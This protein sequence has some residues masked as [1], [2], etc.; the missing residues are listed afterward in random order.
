MKYQDLLTSLP[1]FGFDSAGL[2]VEA[3]RTDGTFNYLANLNH[4]GQT[5]A[6]ALRMPAIGADPASF[7]SDKMSMIETTEFLHHLL[8]RGVKLDDS[9]TLHFTG[10]SVLVSSD[11]VQRFL[12]H[13][14]ALP[15]LQMTDRILNR[16][17]TL[18]GQAVNDLPDDIAH[19]I[20]SYQG[21]FLFSVGAPAWETLEEFPHLVDKV[22]CALATLHA[23]SGRGHRISDPVALDVL[24]T[25]ES[26]LH[27]DASSW[28]PA[29]N[30][31]EGRGLAKSLRRWNVND[32]HKRRTLV[33]R[34]R[35]LRSDAGRTVCRQAFNT[36]LP[37][38][39]STASSLHCFSHGDAHGGNFVTVQY[40]Y[41]LDQTDVV[42]DRVF[43]NDIFQQR[44]DIHKVAVT[45]LDD[46]IA[47]D[48]V[49]AV[50]DPTCIAV[51][52]PHFEVHPIDLDTATVSSPGRDTLHLYDAIVFSLS[53]S[54]ILRLHGNEAL[55]TD[56]LSCYLA[57]LDHRLGHRR[58]SIHIAL[59]NDQP[60]QSDHGGGCLVQHLLKHRKSY[61]LKGF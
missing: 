8:N 46:T 5:W 11:S 20:T 17:Q 38:S 10:Q 9:T 15:A 22:A 24:R 26:A 42:V 7:L 60:R 47:L 41:I 3:F 43:L 55:A 35:F 12:Q 44:P 58:R 32:D 50:S 52:N 6:A 40:E 36:A 29:P 56:T 1:R 45:I 27:K 34:E 25:V 18:K 28:Q 37:D 30:S 21:P 33:T 39:S 2:R 51:R 16:E 59:S 53:T 54:N 31:S 23:L 61:K 49:D 4:Y 19:H 48:S 13:Q 14:L 57:A